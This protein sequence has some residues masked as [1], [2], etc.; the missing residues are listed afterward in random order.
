M[1]QYSGDS[2]G[3]QREVRI[4]VT[5]A[6]SSQAKWGLRCAVPFFI[7]V[8][9][10]IGMILGW[11]ALGSIR[12]NAAM[13]GLRSAKWAVYLGFAFTVA[14]GVIGWSA[15]QYNNVARNGPHTALQ[16]GQ[17]GD[18]AGFIAQFESAGDVDDM[19]QAFAFLTL[20]RD[21]YGECDSAALV[22]PDGWYTSWRPFEPFDYDMHF[23]GATLPA[24]VQIVIKPDLDTL[25]MPR[26]SYITLH[27]SAQGD[28]RFPPDAA[29]HSAIKAMAAANEE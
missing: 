1:S 5:A 18:V 23:E 9:P 2:F 11:L 24:T 14:Q 21:R 22:L 10:F 8:L 16:M 15:W 26:M 17:D 27:D 29:T 3:Q 4:E 6:H 20:L 19:E 28:L 25:G 13:D 7:P 12:K